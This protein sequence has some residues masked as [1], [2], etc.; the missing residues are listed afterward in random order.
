MLGTNQKHMDVSLP[1]TLKLAIFALALLAAPLGAAAEAA[2]DFRSATAALGKHVDDFDELDDAPG[3]PSLLERQWE[4]LR[5]VSARWL[6]NHPNA[7]SSALEAAVKAL[8]PMDM[9]AHAVRLDAHSWLVAASINEIGTVFI[10][11]RGEHGFRAAWAI[12]RPETWASRPSGRL[13]AWLPENARGSCRS[14]ATGKRYLECGPLFA[15]I[16]LLPSRAG[17]GFYV[18]GEYAQVAGA[19]VGGQ[20]S[21]WSWDGGRARP[22]FSHGYAYMADQ[23][24]TVRFKGDLLEIRSKEIQRHLYACGA[25]EGRQVVS[26]FRVSRA[27]AV[28]LG[29]HSLTPELDLIDEVY[30]RIA[31]KR[32]T[33]DLASPA[34]TALMAAQLRR[35]DADFKPKTPEDRGVGMIGAWRVTPWGDK[36]RLCLETDEG[37]RAVF[38]L[39][40]S[41]KGLRIGSAVALPVGD[42]GGPGSHS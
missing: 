37:G 24:W 25:C 26:T 31:H 34:A 6:D 22:V 40:P 10:L 1:M 36:R 42:C 20:L 29:R 14:N 4:A 8:K 30:D 7:S 16:G 28:P 9:E 38:T 17:R 27:G 35:G 5:T 11:A 32:P 41:R 2:G 39:Q 3:S 23:P 13:A 33:G 15:R 19:T 18:D 12:D 21:V